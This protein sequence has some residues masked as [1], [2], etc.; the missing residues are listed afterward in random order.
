MA[1]WLHWS[2]AHARSFGPRLNGGESEKPR[3]RIVIANFAPLLVV[4][5]DFQVEEKVKDPT[6]FN[7]A[8]DFKNFPQSTPKQALDSV[9][10]A[11]A[12]KR[13]DYLL[14]QLAD[15]AFVDQ[16]VAQTAAKMNQELSLPQRQSLAFD[17]LVKSTADG[18]LEDPTKLRELQRFLEAGDWEDTVDVAIGRLKGVQSRKVFM[19]KIAPDRWVLL[20]RTQ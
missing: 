16:R 8:L 11:I 7:I 2:S 4:S 5:A 6:R 19:Q 14:A 17:Q 10:K 9:I 15:P 12:E 3:M 20:D 1:N 18:F 13:I